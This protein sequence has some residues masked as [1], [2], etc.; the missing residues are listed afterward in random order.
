MRFLRVDL[1][2]YFL[3]FPLYSLMLN[4]VSMEGTQDRSARTILMPWL[5]FLWDSY[6]L[7]LD[8]LRSNS[9]LEKLYHEVAHDGKSWTL[10]TTF[11]YT[12]QLI[13]SA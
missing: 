5:K 12:L 2:A 13:T 8:L 9:K 6:R 10:L 3:F 7:V 4:A 11:S 1:S